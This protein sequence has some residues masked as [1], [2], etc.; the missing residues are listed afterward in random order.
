MFQIQP[1]AQIADVVIIG[2]GAGGGTMVKVLTDLGVN[3]TLLEAGPMVNPEIDFKQGMWPYEVPHRGAGPDAEY[4]DGKLQWG[5]FQAPNG[6]WDIPGEPYTV[7]PDNRFAWCRSRII[8]GRT[9][10][11]GRFTPRFSDYDFKPYSI[12]GLGS[13]WPIGY[14]EMSPYFDKAEAFI[15]VTGSNEGLRNAPN[16]KFLPPAQPRVHEVL[17]RKAGEKLGIPMIPA[18]LAMLTRAIDGRAACHY[19]AQCGRGCKT[20]S[21]FSSSQ[22]MIFPAMKTGRLTILTGS[23]ARE[24]ILDDT[25]KIGAVQYIDKLTMTEQQIR[26]RT[27][28][29]AASACES[30]R[31]LL[32]SKSASFPNGLANGSGAVG[33]YLTDTVGYSL[34]GYVPALEGVPRHNTDGLSGGHL[35]FPW[36]LQEQKNKNFPRGNHVQVGGGFYMPGLGSFAGEAWNREGYGSK[37][38]D[39]I[40]QTYGSMVVFSGLGEMIPNKDSYCEIDPDGLIDQYGIPVLRFHWKWTDYELKQ[41]DH[42]RQTFLSLIESMGGTASDDDPTLTSDKRIRTGGS[43]IHELGTV[44]MGDDPSQAPLNR[45]CQAHDVKN[46]FVADGGP[47]VSNP[48]KNPTLAIVALAWRTAEHLAEELRKGNV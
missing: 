36:W 47:F 37:L 10:H 16:G 32:N 45:W 15:G 18:R 40:R 42:M 31:L 2:S 48:E 23:M 12:D 5:Y 46:L 3:V 30:A 14:D 17:M 11:F 24:L 34:W 39:R 8:G 9:N 41:V 33:K 43:V 27:V 28:V 35:Y 19:C 25:G 44:R 38:K 4:Y 22:A 7:S 6:Y 1:K 13:D 20:A 21:A 29:L 26:C